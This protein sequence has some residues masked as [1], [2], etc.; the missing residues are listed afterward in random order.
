M[1][2][3]EEAVQLWAVWAIHH[4]CTKNPDRYCG[5]LAAQGGHVVL[6]DLVREPS[7]HTMVA[8]I[9]EKVKVHLHFMEGI[10]KDIVSTPYKT[11]SIYGKLSQF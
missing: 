1:P 3:Q 2:R 4:V 8:N 9:T 5:M 11:L 7:T 10:K 6:L